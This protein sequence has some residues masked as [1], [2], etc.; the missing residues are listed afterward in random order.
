MGN[1]SNS[2]KCLNLKNYNHAKR[3]KRARYSRPCD[4]CAQTKV[5]CDTQLPCSRCVK[6]NIPCT[7]SRFESKPETITKDS[8]LS[9]AELRVVK[10]RKTL[11]TTIA[12]GRL[13]PFLHIYKSYY[14][15]NWPIIPVKSLLRR[16]FLIASD[17]IEATTENIL[18]YSLLCAVAAAVSNQL[19][20]LNSENPIN[21]K[22]N[23]V[24]PAVFADEAI[25]IRNM[26]NFRALQTMDNVLISF[27]LYI[28]YV[29][30][31]GGMSC[32]LMYMKEAINFT[33]LMKLH[34]PKVYK[35]KSPRE[36]HILTKFYYMLLISERYMCIEENLPVCLEHSIPLPVAED[37][38]D[39][40]RMRG[41]IE[42]VKSFAAPNRSFFDTLVNYYSNGNISHSSWVPKRP[43]IVQVQENLNS[44][45][46]A[47]ASGQTQYMNVMSSK[48]WM[49]SL[50]WNISLR[51]HI[52]LECS[53]HGSLTF[54][55]PVCI[56]S[57]FLNDTK[58]CSDFAFE[59]NG[60]GLCVKILEIANGVAD[61][62]NQTNN[63]AYIP[64]L[65]AIFD[66]VSKYRNDIAMPQ[67]I[68]TKVQNFL[69]LK[70]RYTTKAL[71]LGNDEELRS[72]FSMKCSNDTRLPTLSMSPEG[73]FHDTKYIKS[74]EENNDR[75]AEEKELKA[76]TY[77]SDDEI[78]GDKT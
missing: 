41:F 66:L 13:I 62:I 16:A 69:L 65:Q 12:I 4:K 70:S 55:Y 68:Y 61:S 73:L 33:Q 36:I 8:N 56:A 48:H 77:E 29:N 3:T 40:V 60:P 49:R 39:P 34:D 27:L 54:A 26:I 44:I 47:H 57:D 75:I 50:V 71:N 35:S 63:I 9:I 59:S 22:L 30:I 74:F 11:G 42:L 10:L 45:E 23:G 28:Y 38:D 2:W 51:S 78:P 37:D 52:L 58:D 43:W 24:D 25:R 32:G 67:N 31:R 17:P 64:I 7:L 20:F 5:K 76:I 15:G 46:F 18:C 72:A 14:Y 6:R 19:T 53:E 1:A 21:F